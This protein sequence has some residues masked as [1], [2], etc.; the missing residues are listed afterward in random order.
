[1]ATGATELTTDYDFKKI[2]DSDMVPGSKPGPDNTVVS[3]S[4]TGSQICMA[5]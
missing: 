5:Q 1:M 4:S 2:M 3:G